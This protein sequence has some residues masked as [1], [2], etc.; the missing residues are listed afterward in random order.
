MESFELSMLGALLPQTVSAVVLIAA[1]V[2]ALALRARLGS[3]ATWLTVAAATIGAVDFMA[4]AWWQVYGIRSVIEDGGDSRYTVISVVSLVFWFFHL[5][6][7][8]L[9]IVAVFVGRR[10]PPAEIAVKIS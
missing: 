4:G 3:A 8:S 10:R 2:T 5:V 6:W 1:G 7:T 9:L